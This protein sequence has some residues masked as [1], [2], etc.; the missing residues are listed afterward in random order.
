MESSRQARSDERH[1]MPGTGR[2]FLSGYQA[3]E[4]QVARIERLLR[5]RLASQVRPVADFIG[6]SYGLLYKIVFHLQYAIE[7]DNYNNRFRR[8]CRFCNILFSERVLFYPTNESV[9]SSS[10]LLTFEF[11]PRFATSC[12]SSAARTGGSR[13]R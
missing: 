9:R 2:S 11:R 3:G 8:K 12:R 5:L 1:R 4:F 10:Y 6:L 7:R 13:N